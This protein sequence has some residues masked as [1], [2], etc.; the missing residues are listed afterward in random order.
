[1]GVSSRYITKNRGLYVFLRKFDILNR[2]KSI[3][4]DFSGDIVRK[5]K[6]LFCLFS[7][8]LSS[9]VIKQ[10]VITLLNNRDR[11]MTSFEK[12]IEDFFIS[13][14]DLVEI[15]CILFLYPQGCFYISI[16]R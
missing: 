6:N 8:S 1:M 2:F 7:K 15:F 11:L 12:D 3:V 10:W 9:W 5:G 13:L 16:I 14:I 4:S